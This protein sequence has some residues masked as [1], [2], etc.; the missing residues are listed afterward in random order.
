MMPSKENK[1]TEKNKET[2]ETNKI[3]ANE[4]MLIEVTKTLPRTAREDDIAKSCI[5]SWTRA[6]H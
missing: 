3:K 2:K 5:A 4:E 6:H 1:E